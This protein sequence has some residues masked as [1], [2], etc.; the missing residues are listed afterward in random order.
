LTKNFGIR[1][2]ISEWKGFIHPD[3]APGYPS[4]YNISDNGDN[5]EKCSRDILIC[6]P[7]FT[8]EKNDPYE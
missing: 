3:Y 5:K 8:S 6:F 1:E 7:G 2:K 4:L